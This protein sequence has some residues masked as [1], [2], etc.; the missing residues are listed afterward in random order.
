MINRQESENAQLSQCRKCCR[1]LLLRSVQELVLS[2]VTMNDLE[3]RAK[4]KSEVFVEE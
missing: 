3:R 4:R 2:D 1:G